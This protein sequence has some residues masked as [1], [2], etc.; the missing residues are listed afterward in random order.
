MHKELKYETMA[1]Q[2]KKSIIKQEPNRNYQ[3]EKHNN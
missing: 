1:H 3:L 2:V